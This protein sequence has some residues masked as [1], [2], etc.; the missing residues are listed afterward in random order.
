M[1]ATPIGRV[2]T[3]PVCAVARVLTAARA[4][5]FATILFGFVI[6]AVLFG[7]AKKVGAVW[8]LAASPLLGALFAALQ[9]AVPYV[10]SVNPHPLRDRQLMTVIR[11]VEQREHAG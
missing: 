7:L 8:W 1:T 3:L 9:L 10:V 2:P 6:F 5:L 11:T 4:W